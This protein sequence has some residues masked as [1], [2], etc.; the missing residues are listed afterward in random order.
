M[1]VEPGGGAGAARLC[2]EE[3]CIGPAASPSG[4]PLPGSPW[5]CR[6]CP[7]PLVSAPAEGPARMGVP[8]G[9]VTG[10]PL[11]SH[12]L[13]SASGRVTSSC[14]PPPTPGAD[15]SR[16]FPPP[17]IPATPRPVAGCGADSAGGSPRL[18]TTR[19]LVNGRLSSAEHVVSSA[20][21]CVSRA[22]HL[23]SL[24]CPAEGSRLQRAQAQG[25]S[26]P[27]SQGGTQHRF[28]SSPGGPRL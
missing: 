17:L 26:P 10:R 27:L 9:A 22:A 6:L 2:R 1:P 5:P 24:G 14:Q 7:S 16:T 19:P 8:T 25:P 28:P 3:Q 13:P 21:S 20:V 15:T 12:T 11:S 4:G 18:G 23:A